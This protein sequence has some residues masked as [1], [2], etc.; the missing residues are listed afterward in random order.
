MEHENQAGAWISMPV[1]NTELAS[2]YVFNTNGAYT[3]YDS[4]NSIYGSGTWLIVGDNTQLTLNK[5]ITYD[6][7]ILNDTT[8]QLSLTEQIPYSDL[9]TGITITRYGMREAFT[10]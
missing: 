7:S 2:L 4:T 9:L 6:F 10:H 3:I 1:S 5:S 8:M